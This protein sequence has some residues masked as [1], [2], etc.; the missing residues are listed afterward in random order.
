VTACAFWLALS[1]VTLLV[2][3]AE[4]DWNQRKRK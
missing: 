3:L 4:L 2:L 1:L